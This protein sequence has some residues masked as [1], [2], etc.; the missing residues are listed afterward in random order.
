MTLNASSIKKIIK[1][2]FCQKPL[3]V[4]ATT[5]QEKK[6]KLREIQKEFKQKIAKISK[7]SNISAENS[8]D[9]KDT[10]YYDGKKKIYLK[11]SCNNKNYYANEFVKIF[12]K[13]HKL[14]VTNWYFSFFAII[15]GWM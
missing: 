13:G 2:I 12:F 7:S 5:D 11:I 9:S 8:F 4:A 6:E 3:E 1:T 14:Y 15:T 10:S